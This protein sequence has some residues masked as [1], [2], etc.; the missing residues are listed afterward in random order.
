MHWRK[1]DKLLLRSKRKALPSGTSDHSLKRKDRQIENG[2][3]M[4]E[5]TFNEEWPKVHDTVVNLLYQRP[6]DKND[7]Q[8]IFPTI[9][10]I[11]SWVDDGD[12]QI[13]QALSQDIARYVDEAEKTVLSKKI[14]IDLLH[15]YITEWNRFYHQSSILPLPFKPLEK[16]PNNNT[17]EQRRSPGVTL[18]IRQVMFDTWNRMIFGK[19]AVRLLDA[20]MELVEKERR[21]EQVDP[22]LISGV[23]ESFVALHESELEPLEAYRSS[24]ERAYVDRTIAFYKLESAQFIELNGVRDYMAFADQ[25]LEEEEQRAEKYL[26]KCGVNRLIDA[27]VRV[28]VGDFEDQLLSECT[29]LIQTNDIERLRMLYRLIKRTPAGIETVLK[30]IDEHIRHEGTQDM[31]AN[32]ETVTTDPEKYVQQLLNNFEKFSQLIHDGFYDDP[33]VLTARDKAFKD[34]VNDPSVFRLE[35]NQGKKGRMA[36]ESKCPELLANYC[37]L[38]LRKTPLSKRLTSEEIETRL[39]DVLLVLKYVANK[40]VFMRFHK[41]HLSRRLVLDMTVDLDREET[42]ITRLRERGMPAEHV[43][44]CLRMLSDIELNQGLNHDFKKYLWDSSDFLGGPMTDLL[45]IKI[46]NGGAW[47]RSGGQIDCVRISIPRQLEE[48]LPTVESFYKHKHSGRK[49]QWVHH[50]SNGTVIFNSDFGRYDIEMT[51]FQLAVL[52]CWSERPLDALSFETLRLATELPDSELIRTL[53]SLCAFPKVRSQLLEWDG[54]GPPNPRIFHDST[55]FRLNCQFKIEKNGK[56]QP[57]GRFN[58]IGRLQL[59]LDAAAST[60]HE[61]IVELRKYRVQ[62]AIVKVLKTR[63]QLSA[64]QLQNELVDQLKH[65]FV[66]SR[67]LMKEQLEWLMENRYIERSSSDINTFNYIA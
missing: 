22:K 28:L 61:E 18:S 38:L 58:V 67:Q 1:R 13:R 55:T 51:T 35:L 41:A 66:P 37:D 53:F 9:F 40:D 16:P 48:I 11:H 8:G 49:L 33:R 30:Y 56:V 44:K 57:R 52:Y 50:W 5:T 25:K 43:N 47:G 63:K 10:K 62:E 17:L 6:V 2:D 7:W 20:A 14:N 65:M 12:N 42:L 46:L 59:G 45:T 36:A 31:L 60:E 32:A 21:G 4:V 34:V 15:T 29:K 54:E 26:A 39:D 24:F 19:V 3:V 64:W 27:A 23:R